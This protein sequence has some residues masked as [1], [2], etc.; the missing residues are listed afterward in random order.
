M[1]KLLNFELSKI[2]K[3]K[4]FTVRCCDYYI[5]EALFTTEYSQNNNV[6]SRQFDSYDFFINYNQFTDIYSAPRIYQVIDWLYEKYGIWIGIYE[7]E[8][9]LFCINENKFFSL[10]EIPETF[11]TAQKAYLWAISHVIKN[12]I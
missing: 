12:I 2:L 4:G 1:N 11:E 10:I 3:E 9:C 5:N 6:E 8:E 7:N